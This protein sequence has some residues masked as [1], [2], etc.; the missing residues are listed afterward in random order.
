[1]ATYN[2][3]N[4]IGHAIDSVRASTVEDW[5]LI[6]VGD[7]CTD[8]TAD[9][10]A[11]YGDPRIRFVDLERNCGEQ[12]GPNNVGVSLA[13]GRYLAFLNHDDL[14]MPDRLA[15]GLPALQSDQADLT[16][17][18]AVLVLPDGQGLAL[19]GATTL[20]GR[21][22]PVLAIPASLW[23]MKRELAE[24]VGPW[25]SA[26]GLR[27]QPSQDWLFRAQRAGAR[28][29]PQPYVGAVVIQSGTRRNSYRERAH[30]EHAVFAARIREPGFVEHALVAA[31]LRMA[32]A[33]WAALLR[34]HLAELVR[35]L[36]RRALCRLGVLPPNL[37]HWLNPRRGAFIRKLR[38]LRGLGAT[39]VSPSGPEPR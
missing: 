22:S 1:M 25:H 28:M 9:V 32:D 20:A 19:T 12:S 26:F 35:T 15:R 24:R 33:S 3:S 13:R 16:C 14:W 39:P 18:A 37:R 36:S 31:H 7:A 2:R 11:A 8:D 4:V 5:E 34:F 17:C 6:V 21:Y 29:L 23:L 30:G 27:G 38:R 10:V